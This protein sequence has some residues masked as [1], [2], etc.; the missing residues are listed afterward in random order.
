MAGAVFGD[1]RGWLLLLRALYWTFPVWRGSIMRLIFVA[2]AMFGDV[3]GWLLMLCALYW[4]FHV[5]QAHHHHGTSR[6]WNGW[7]L[8]RT[9]K[10]AWAS[11]W[12]VAL[13]TFYGQ[14]LSLAGRFFFP[15]KLPPPA[16]IRSPG[17]Y[18]YY[19]MAIIKY[20]FTYTYIYIFLL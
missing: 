4:T 1:V 19:F 7:K 12:L 13:R 16:R 14:I 20:V 2:G 8:L 9:K 15:V 3:G 11:H 17:K 5:W 18:L 6:H 10:S